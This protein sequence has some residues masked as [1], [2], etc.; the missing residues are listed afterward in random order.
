MGMIAS[1]R[2]AVIALA[3]LGTGP[4]QALN[5]QDLKSP[6]GAV[7]WLVEEPS[8][9]IV[10][11]EI[12]FA[13][14]ARLDPEGRSGLANLMAGLID[15]GAGDLD[16]VGFSKARDDLSA[17][18][19]FSAGRDSMDVSARMLVE[20]LEPSV[21]L[22]ATA[23][24][25]PRFDPEPLER[26]KAQ[27]VSVIAEA[28]TKPDSVAA[29]AW[30]AA[31]FPGHPYGHPSN[32]TA[33]SVAAITRDDLITVRA[34]LLTRANA[35][36]AVV[37]AIDAEQAGRMVDTVLAGLEQGTLVVRKP[38]HETPPTGLRVIDLDVPQSAAIFGQAGLTRDDPDFIPAYVMNYVLGGGGFASRLMT[39][40]REKRGLAYGVYSY[41]S[42]RA[43]AALYLGS[44]RTVNERMAET[45]EVIKAEWA[46]MAAEG[47]TAD[48]LDRAKRYLTGAFPLSFD[49]NAKIANYLVFVQEENLGIDYIDRRNG[50]I[51]AVTLED[52][53][54][55]AARLLKPDELSIVVVGQPTGL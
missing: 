4:A 54:R 2:V 49:S 1:L 13:G 12:S 20:T 51:E 19:G 27:I 9:P 52:V 6:G 24:A 53:K 3:L 35:R 50:L 18:F 17:R 29:K 32:G 7:F 39:E 33:D 8:I 48:E 14:G 21:A 41:L 47:V 22:L 45:L 38:S 5:I 43:E 34:R 30:S 26:V 55:V 10:A 42:I 36:I 31:T 25:S 28:G 40:V 44:V 11:L 23:L 16:A 46:R 37:G 15:E